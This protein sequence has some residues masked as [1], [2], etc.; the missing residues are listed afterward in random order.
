MILKLNLICFVFM[1]FAAFVDNKFIPFH[2]LTLLI[3]FQLHKW[4]IKNK[5]FIIVLFLFLFKCLL[6][7]FIKKD[8]FLWVFY[9]IFCILLGIF[10]LMRALR[11]FFCK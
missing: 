6:L 7:F 10:F 4:Q 1:L 9:D 8:A 2:L 3:A 11:F 5:D